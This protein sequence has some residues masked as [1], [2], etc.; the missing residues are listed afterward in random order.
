M[1][2]VAVFEDGR[3]QCPRLCGGFINVLGLTPVVLADVPDVKLRDPITLTGT[4]LYQAI[5]G[6]G[7]PEEIPKTLSVI[8]SL[9]KSKAIESFQLE[10]VNNRFYL[11]ELRLS[12]GIK[13]HLTSG[14]RGAMILKVTEEVPDGP[15]HRR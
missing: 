11:H 14:P 15:T 12:G 2:Q 6:M 3:A 13:I 7:L 9:L 5:N 1:R 10:E 8:E 4:Q